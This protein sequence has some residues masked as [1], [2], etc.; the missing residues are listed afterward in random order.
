[1]AAWFIPALKAIIPHV[2][3]GV[4]EAALRPPR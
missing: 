4:G 1:M 3:T 2:G